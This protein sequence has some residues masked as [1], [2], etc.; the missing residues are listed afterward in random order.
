VNYVDTWRLRPEAATRIKNFFVAS[1]YVRTYTDLATM[2]A[3]NEAARRAVNGVI[4]A[5][6]ADVAPCEI[7][8]LQEPEV[9]LPLRAYDRIRF[10][11]GL[12]WEGGPAAASAFGLAALAARA[13][14]SSGDRQGREA[15]ADPTGSQGPT[16]AVAR[17]AS[18]AGLRR[19]RVVG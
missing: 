1:D 8:N 12:P 17:A 15:P 19:L 4:R 5:A 3:A 10:R 7:W 16:T 11:K 2:E 18:S 14:S 6:K 9:F 13:A